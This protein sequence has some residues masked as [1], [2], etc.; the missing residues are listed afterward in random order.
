MATITSVAVAL[1]LGCPTACLVGSRVAGS[2]SPARHDGAGSN[3]ASRHCAPANHDGAHEPAGAHDSACPAD[4]CGPL[5]ADTLRARGTV[6]PPR[7]SAA[8]AGPVAPSARAPRHP[9]V[10][11]S[12]R[13]AA[14]GPSPPGRLYVLTHSWLI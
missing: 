4:C 9:S 12:F 8:A 14:R 7:S 13:V 2:P 5:A 10:A 11:G 3:A 1:A 6:E